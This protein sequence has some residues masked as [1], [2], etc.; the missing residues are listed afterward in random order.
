MI[1]IFAQ[2][3]VQKAPRDV[4]GVGE[5]VIDSCEDGQLFLG[6]ARSFGRSAA[7]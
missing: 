1:A 3:T 5:V 2:V 6:R 7:G 4:I